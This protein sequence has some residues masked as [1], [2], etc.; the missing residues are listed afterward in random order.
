MFKQS[1]VLSGAIAVAA[2]LA[3]GSAVH[4]TG[5]PTV[6]F[7]YVAGA[8]SY[9]VA[10]DSS[11]DIPLFLEETFT[12]GDDLLSSEGGLFNA[13][14]SISTSDTTEDSIT[15]SQSDPGFAGPSSSTG[16]GTD[17]MLME[18]AAIDGPYPDG[19]L[20]SA[21]STRL[22]PLGT[23]TI[24][25]GSDVGTTTY[26]VDR[27]NSLG[28]NTLTAR[29]L[30]DLDA[31]NNNGLPGVTDTTTVPTYPAATASTFELITVPEPASLALAL[32][33]VPGLVGRR[34]R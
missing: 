7:S 21:T 17:N 15:G 11:V 25:T 14:V 13:G 23:V 5:V 20:N 26:D 33:A 18:G 8:A 32:L 6:S 31:T 10:P 12:G 3:A 4:A 19:T 30:Y 29:N 24:D 28:G 34:R 1:R 16:T 2:L 27:Y 9:T 22:I